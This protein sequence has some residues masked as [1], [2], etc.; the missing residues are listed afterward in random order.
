MTVKGHSLGSTLAMLCTFDV[1]ETRAN[2]SSGDDRVAPMCV[3]S[4]TGPLIGKEAVQA[5]TGRAAEFVERSVQLFRADPNVVC[6]RRPTL[7]LSLQIPSCFI[8]CV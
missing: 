3:F 2:V 1:M 4:F 5:G 7:S 8:Q 6:R